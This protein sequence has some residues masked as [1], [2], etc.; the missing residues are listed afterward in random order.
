MKEGYE[1]RRWTHR[2][3]GGEMGG[4]SP[5]LAHSSPKEAMV[6]RCRCEGQ[7]ASD[8]RPRRSR[9]KTQ[10][11]A[12]RR[13]HP[14]VGR[15]LV[16]GTR[17][18]GRGRGQN[19]RNNRTR[20]S[21]GPARA[22]TKTPGRLRGRRGEFT[23]G[24]APLLRGWSRSPVREPPIGE[25]DL[26]RSNHTWGSVLVRVHVTRAQVPPGTGSHRGTHRCEVTST[27]PPRTLGTASRPFRK[28]WFRKSCSINNQ[29]NVSV[30]VWEDFPEYV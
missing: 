29:K 1:R 19:A 13:R 14:A 16:F 30:L 11:D 12:H 4:S 18:E 28:D 22:L 21:D 6:M 23:L 15:H 5:S 7:A 27:K 25:V 2:G 8:A 24:R 20:C 17:A 3:L 26:S 9:G 10:K